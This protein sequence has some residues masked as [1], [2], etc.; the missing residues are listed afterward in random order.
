MKGKILESPQ[1]RFTARALAKELNV[2][3]GRRIERFEDSYDW[4]FRYGN[5][6]YINRTPPIILN[7]RY[8]ITRASHK[9]QCKREMI[10]HDI[11]TP[12]IFLKERIEED[13]NIPYPLIAR[14][15]NHFK[16]IH[17]YMVKNQDEARHYLRRGYYIQEVIDNDTEYRVFIFRDKVFEVNVKKQTGQ[18][19]KNEL[20]R[21]FENGWSFYFQAV[22]DT[23]QELKDLCRRAMS[24]VNLDWG[25]IDCCVDKKG[26][27][28]IFEI[29]SAPS[30]I[31]RKISKLALKVAEYIKGN[32]RDEEEESEEDE[33]EDDEI[34]DDY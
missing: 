19:K 22:S 2:P 34:D 8:N 33:C 28:Y 7:K 25:A 13:D 3:C 16:G 11:P 32:G 30:L 18:G 14:P 26:R 6:A 9:F 23:R 31:E 27:I 4:I 15:T 1:A 20:I 21:N 24:M 29:N 12:R 5:I 17:F 10:K